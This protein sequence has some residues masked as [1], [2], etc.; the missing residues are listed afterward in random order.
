MST[1]TSTFVPVQGRWG[2]YPCSWEHYK[3]LKRLNWLVLQVRRQDAAYKRWERKQPQ[4][5]RIYLGFKYGGVITP[6]PK[7][8]TSKCWRA[9]KPAPEPIMAE[10]YPLQME[11]IERDYQSARYPQGEATLVKPLIFGTEQVDAYLQLLEQWLTDSRAT[12]PEV[13]A[14]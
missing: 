1:T 6:A 10:I 14:E 3:K 2:F 8:S 7:R 12:P 5:R 11:Y 13:K 9:Y 4:N